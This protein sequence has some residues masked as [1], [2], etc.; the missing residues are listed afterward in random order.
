MAL[1]VLVVNDRRQTR[2]RVDE[3]ES[4]RECFFLTFVAGG[5]K[6]QK[7]EKLRDLTKFDVIIDE[8]RGGWTLLAIKN[9]G[10]QRMRR[11]GIKASV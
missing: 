11:W 7:A 9:G 5:R 10:K 6:R 2:R 4:R 1:I 8:G 3:F